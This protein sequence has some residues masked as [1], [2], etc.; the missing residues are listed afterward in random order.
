MATNHNLAVVTDVT[1]I[2]HSGFAIES[3]EWTFIFDFYID[4]S[5]ILPHILKRSKNIVFLVSHSHP[6]HFNPAIFD[7]HQKYNNITYILSKDVKAKTKGRILPDSTVFIH[8]GDKI[9]FSNFQV[10]AFSST[11]IGCSFLLSYENRNIF[12]AGDLNNWNWKEESTESEIKKANGDYLHI[13]NTIQEVTNSFNLVMF[14]VDPR[15]KKDFFEGAKQFLER[16]FVDNFIP[17]HFWDDSVLACDFSLYKSAKCNN[18]ICLSSPG[19]SIKI[20]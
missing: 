6:D 19:D 12:H 3:G 11:D 9:D 14:P 13:L 18:Y 2:G 10:Q 8:P 5:D 1:Y 16:F 20:E 4:E 17:M 7:W 15:M